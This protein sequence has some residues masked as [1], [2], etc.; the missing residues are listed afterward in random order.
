M[1]A[2][3]IPNKP[4]CRRWKNRTH[5]TQGLPQRKNQR[6]QLC[7]TKIKMIAIATYATKKYFYCWQ[8]VLRHI[9]A[10]ASHHNEAVFILA[11][12]KSEEA[13]NAIEV[14]R[15]ELPE[16]WKITSINIDVDDSC[17]KKY[18][19]ES[20]ILIA[21]LQGAAFSFARKIRAT[22]LWSVESDVLV[23]A[24]SLRVSEWVLQ[25]PQADGSPYYDV[26]AVTYPNG[27]FLGGFGSY[28]SAINEDFTMEEK[29]IPKR[30]K[31]AIDA[32]NERLKKCNDKK[33]AEKEVN[34]M[35][36]LRERLKRI[37]PDG[38]IWEVIAKHG[39][40]RRGWMDFAYPAIGRGSIVP[41]DWCGLG[42]TLL[43]E[44][45]LSLATFEGYDG[46][47]TQDLYLCWHR[48]HPHGLKIACVPHTTCDHVKP[49]RGKNDDGSNELIVHHVAS[50]QQEGEMRGHLRSKEQPW[51]QV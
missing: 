50:H 51:I 24:E 27:M 12:D 45:A 1:R 40:R 26:A 19:Q 10:A 13:K 39:W 33:S 20:Q 16:G 22:S 18:K 25:M 29:K 36:R 17:G 48:W 35:G 32:C 15:R 30:L 5:Q 23:S 8:S 43:S 6:S 4:S 28:Q 44:K 14:A 21:R 3:Q 37:P 11:T 7:Q 34:R 31:I 46:R 38:N 2:I 49:K 9:A 41:S 47:G 42:C